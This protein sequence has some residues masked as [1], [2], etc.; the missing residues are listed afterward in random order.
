VLLAAM[1]LIVWSSR[2]MSLAQGL[3]EKPEELRACVLLL[4]R[5]FELAEAA[6]ELPVR[7]AP[8][9]RDS[10]RMKPDAANVARRRRARRG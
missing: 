8:E 5:L 2:G 9:T 4:R 7:P 1:R 6:N 3:T 10:P